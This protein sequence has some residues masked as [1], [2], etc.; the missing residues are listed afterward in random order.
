V[1]L[2]HVTC[3]YHSNNNK[4]CISKQ[5]NSFDFW[6]LALTPDCKLG[7]KYLDFRWITV[8]LDGFDLSEGID[9]KISNMFDSLSDVSISLICLGRLKSV[10]VC[11]PQL[12]CADHDGQFF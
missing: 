3:T 12:V 6:Q 11:D 2:L 10:V 7:E 5:Q 1:S 9:W 8:H 4:I